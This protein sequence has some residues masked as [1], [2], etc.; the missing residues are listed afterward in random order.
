MGLDTKRISK[1]A[2]GWTGRI[3]F[4]KIRQFH[5]GLIGQDGTGQ[6]I[7]YTGIPNY[8]YQTQ[9]IQTAD[10]LKRRKQGYRGL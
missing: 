10:T 2:G 4:Q 9:R 3:V 1:V 8:Q 7:D 5:T 6:N